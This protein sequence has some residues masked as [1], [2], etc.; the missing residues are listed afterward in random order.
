MSYWTETAA[1]QPPDWLDRWM[2]QMESVISGKSDVIEHLM[3]ACLSE[4]H[5]LLEDVPGVGKTTLV[6]ALAGSIGCAFKRIQFTPDQMPSDITGMSA[7][8]PQSMEFVYKPGPIMANVVLADE[9]NRASP[10]TQSALLEAMEERRVTVDGTS[11][12]LPRPFMLLATQNPLSHEGTY[13]LPEAQMDRFMFRLSLGYPGLEQEVELLERVRLNHPL[14]RIEPVVAAD[15][16]LE[17]QQEVR[18]V[19]VEAGVKQYI[20]RISEATRRHP[21]IELGA[22]PRGS[23]AL[24]K[25][26]QARAW[27]R[28]RSYVLPD[29]VKGLALP[30]LAHRVALK[31]TAAYT[32]DGAYV[33]KLLEALVDAVSSAHP[34]RGSR[35]EAERGGWPG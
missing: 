5:V 12:A 24:M 17:A 34:W 14:A 18:H 20:V 23:I 3:I 4:G 7:L 26:A 30:V 32:R 28:G 11:H 35:T 31:P 13:T 10:K 1:V 25:A 21:D 22:S 8:E 27:M 9:L 19:Y 16:L 15:K 29:D 6:Q 2:R 33:R